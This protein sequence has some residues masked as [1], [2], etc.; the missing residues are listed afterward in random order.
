[1]YNL[2]CKSCHIYIGTIIYTTIFG[3]L[4]ESYIYY[5]TNNIDNRDIIANIVY[6]FLVGVNFPKITILFT[7]KNIYKF[8][9]KYF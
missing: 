9:N 6:W 8:I 2:I 4:R 3:I 5:R 1:M 7:Y